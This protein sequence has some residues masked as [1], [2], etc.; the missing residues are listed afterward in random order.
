MNISTRWGPSVIVDPKWKK[1]SHKDTDATTKSS[2]TTTSTASVPEPTL[3]DVDKVVPTVTAPAVA[4]S[5]VPPEPSISETTELGDVTSP[6]GENSASIN[7]SIDLPSVEVA[8]GSLGTSQSLIPDTVRP[9]GIA[10]N[11]SI[12]NINST[13]SAVNNND[14]FRARFN[15]SRGRVL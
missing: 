4:A 1:N 9:V 8:S 15:M 7:K 3:V 11:V 6:N 5:I 14:T 13:D 10:E 2:E 12:G